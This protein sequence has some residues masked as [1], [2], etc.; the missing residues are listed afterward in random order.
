M[1]ERL[2]RQLLP[3]MQLGMQACW[4]YAWL[5]LIEMR[6]LGRIS[7]AP[8]AIL[9]AV[10]GAFA[11]AGV[12]RLPL[13]RVARVACYWV[14]WFAIAT[15]VG[16]YLLYP[17]MAWGQSDW[18][19]AL[20][21]SLLRLIFETQPAELLLLCGSACAWYLGGRAVSSPA[22]YETLL[23]QFQFGLLLLFGAFLLAHGLGV[24]S[25][26]PVLLSLA[27]FALSLTGIAI[28]RSRNGSEPASVPSG[29]HFTGSLLTLVVVVSVLGLLAG[30]AITPDLVGTFIDAGRAILHSL[31]SAL[32]FLFSLFPAPDVPSG[33]EMEPPATGED[34][35][36]LEFYRTLPWPA[37]LR[38]A[39]F[40][41]WVVVVMGM[42]LFALWRLCSSLLE[43]L[44]RRS[45]VSGIEIESLDTGLLADLLALLLWLDR[46][47][48]QAA[49]HVARFARQKMGAT[50]E[51]TWTSVYAGLVHWAARKVLPREPS[52]S[53]HE[54]QATLSELLP[55]ATADLAFV[56]DTYARARYG[57][58]EPDGSTVQEMHSAVH[59]I[60]RAPRRRGA[61]HT[62][63]Q[64]EG[65]E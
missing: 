39:L 1:R 56:T 22:T 12:E 30:I 52:Q 61:D 48:R 42:F 26:H 10:L 65:A 45:N 32:A 28:T 21:R 13:K 59:R 23:G 51:P 31:G 15:F 29:R 40:I 41:V 5:S 25:G 64:T 60:R 20:P 4:L 38:R 49:N 7:I 3:T 34:A 2:K 55:A 19:F 36:L 27:F 44:K 62:N 47:V 57:G 53:A 9:F 14:L 6:L 37:L 50:G 18:V 16:K 24:A 46:R 35:S 33:A 43:W 8:A 58:H 11:R 54:Y 17:A 63:T